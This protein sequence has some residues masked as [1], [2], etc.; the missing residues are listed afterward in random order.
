MVKKNDE[1]LV[2]DWIASMNT[3]EV[4]KYLG[5]FAEDAVLDDP[6]VGERFEGH[7]GIADYF[8][9]Y[10]VGYNTTT[11]PIS[12]EARDDHLHVIVDF[13]GDFPGGQTP[14]IFD[15]TIAGDKIVFV[16]ADLT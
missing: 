10:F 13:T 16:H 7:D 2:F 12:T 5:H 15:V 6:S 11:R 14:G 4:E 9:R 3:H 1:A 8:A